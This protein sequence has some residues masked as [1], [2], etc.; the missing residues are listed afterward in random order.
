MKDAL[1]SLTQ[2]AMFL[3]WIM[4]FVVAKGFWSTLFCLIP[5][6]SWYLSI[7]FILTRMGWL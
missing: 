6:W 3:L 7:E 1:Y 2:T 4:G 5:F